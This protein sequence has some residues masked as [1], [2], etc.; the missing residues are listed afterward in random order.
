MGLAMAA[1]CL[2]AAPRTPAA[3]AATVST[4]EALAEALRRAQPG[5]TIAL[6]PGVYRLEFSNFHGDVTITS[7][8]P[9]HRA[10]FQYLYVKSSSGIRFTDLEWVAPLRSADV[11][12]HFAFG[13]AHGSH[14]RFDHLDVHSL[15]GGTLTTLNQGL[16]ISDSDHVDVSD[17]D[18]HDLMQAVTHSNGEYLTFQRNHFHHLQDDGLSGAGS[19][20]VLV[21]ANRCDSNHPDPRDDGHPDCIQF[22]TGGTTTAAHD[23]T[24]TNNVYVRGDGQNTQGIFITDAGGKLGYEHV[25][26][27]GNIILGAIWHGILVNAKDVVIEDNFVC[28]YPDQLSWISVQKSGH[29]IVQHNRATNFQFYQIGQLEASD[30]QVVGRCHPSDDPALRHPKP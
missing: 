22:W 13:I 28:G 29:A 16:R 8:D 1:A 10:V 24:V 12:P 4:D 25:T 27:R 18:F 21:D 11:K 26:I 3:A 30:N 2:A 9:A 6:A 14:I 5:E 20:N 19:S 17:N 7:A 15:P 23:I